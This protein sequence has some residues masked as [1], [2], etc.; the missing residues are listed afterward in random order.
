M[1]VEEKSNHKN[2]SLTIITKLDGEGCVYNPKTLRSQI[3][4][5]QLTF[6]ILP[7]IHQ[8]PYVANDQTCRIRIPLAPLSP[9]KGHSGAW[10]SKLWF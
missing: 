9:T 4:I 8:R 3:I 2:N 7:L 6:D 1:A 5:E 10:L